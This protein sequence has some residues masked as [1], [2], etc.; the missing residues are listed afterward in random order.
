M[1][2]L[3][4]GILYIAQQHRG[5]FPAAS[6]HDGQCIKA[7]DKHVLSSANAHRVTRQSFDGTLLDAHRLRCA[8]DQTADGGGVEGS[9]R[10]APQVECPEQGP[11]FNFRSL[12]PSLKPIN[13]VRR[14]PC[15]PAVSCLIAFGSRDQY[16]PVL[17]C[18]HP[19]VLHA[20]S[21]K[22]AAAARC[23]VAAWSAAPGHARLPCRSWPRTTPMSRADET[24][25]SSPPR[26][27]V[28]LPIRQMRIP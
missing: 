25:A 15:N 22:L 1:Q 12:H 11:L 8:F 19:H 9:L 2:G 28:D 6:L 21:R 14:E 18:R 27:N 24:R 5:R 3:R 16:A 4:R 10:D 17:S 13:R 26:Q 20:H 23:D 7:R